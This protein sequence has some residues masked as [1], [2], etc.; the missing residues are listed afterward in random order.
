M[1]ARLMGDVCFS[2]EPST[3]G[4]DSTGSGP[5]IQRVDGHG[6]V[7]LILGKDQQHL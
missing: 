6:T 7:V 5:G 4:D 3:G 2:H 1:I